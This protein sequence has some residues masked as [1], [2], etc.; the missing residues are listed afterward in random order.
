[1]GLCQSTDA[2]TGATSESGKSEEQLHE[3]VNRLKKMRELVFEEK[4]DLDFKPEETPAMEKDA[5]TRALIKTAVKKN[6]KMDWIKDREAD[7]IARYATRRA[8]SAGQAVITQGEEG[9]EFFVIGKGK[10]SVID[11]ETQTTV[12]TLPKPNGDG[13]SFGELALLVNAP[14]SHTIKADIDGEVGCGAE[15]ISLCN[16]ECQREE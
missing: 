1:M 14:R 16:C 6:P 8:V 15:N 3:K 5:E 13:T 4:P 2:T 9:H 7:Y 11:E 12:V 10:F